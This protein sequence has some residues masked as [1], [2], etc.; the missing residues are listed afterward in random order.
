MLRN[1]LILKIQA[2]DVQCFLD[3]KGNPGAFAVACPGV[4]EVEV[5]PQL[6]VHENMG[7]SDECGQ[8]VAVQT[9]GDDEASRAQEFKSSN[10]LGP[11]TLVFAIL[12]LGCRRAVGFIT[13]GLWRVDVRR[14]GELPVD[15]LVGDLADA[16]AE[17]H[18][19]LSKFNVG[20][21]AVGNFHILSSEDEN[22]VSVRLRKRWSE[23]VKVMLRMA[24]GTTERKYSRLLSIDSE[25]GSVPP[26]ERNVWNEMAVDSLLLAKRLVEPVVAG[27]IACGKLQI[28][29]LPKSLFGRL[30]ALRVRHVNAL[31][32][33][34]D[35]NVGKG[36][37]HLHTRRLVFP[38]VVVEVAA[39]CH[40]N[41]RIRAVLFKDFAK[42][43][44]I[45]V[46]VNE[47]VVWR[48]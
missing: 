47:P 31:G 28:F 26:H 1:L 4:V 11:C 22:I 14:V 23:Y 38:V 24:C 8:N 35:R 25:V 17:V 27:L 41:G 20:R 42:F 16:A 6:A 13:S 2:C 18:F 43:P 37:N 32:E 29:V 36:F 5:L 34:S 9:V 19:A 12:S 10:G 33:C 30:D 39:T 40:D 7:N 15:F 45:A 21:V 44:D 48:E 46:S 3:G